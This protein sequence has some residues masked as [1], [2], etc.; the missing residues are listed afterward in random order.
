M[1]PP[2]AG[3]S[4]AMFG[5]RR[6][7]VTEQQTE[8]QRKNLLQKCLVFTQRARELQAQDPLTSLVSDWSDMCTLRSMR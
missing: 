2:G 5:F 7:Q 3:E 4:I 8:K 6:I 1:P